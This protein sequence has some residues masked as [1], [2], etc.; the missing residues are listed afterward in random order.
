MDLT[1]YESYLNGELF[2][3]SLPDEELDKYQ[4]AIKDLPKPEIKKTGRW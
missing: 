4:A 2:D 1:G 3:Y